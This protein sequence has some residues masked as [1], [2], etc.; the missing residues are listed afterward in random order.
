MVAPVASK[1]SSCSP[2]FGAVFDMVLKLGVMI[3]VSQRAVVARGGKIRHALR[4]HR[5]DGLR[6]DA[7]LKERLVEIAHIVG[8]D[9]GARAA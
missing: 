3:V 2:E 4:F 8:D 9:L 6:D 5:V 7:V 1:F